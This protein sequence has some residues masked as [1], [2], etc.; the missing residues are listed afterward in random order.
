MKN[1]RLVTTRFAT[2]QDLINLQVEHLTILINKAYDE[3]ELGMWQNPGTRTNFDEVEHLIRAGALIIAEI[4]GTLV[5]SVNVTLMNEGVGE[6]GML[7][8]DP[9][10]R[11][12]GVGSALVDRAEDWARDLGCHT[13]Q[14]ELLTPRRWLHQNKEI[15]KVWY[16]N[17]G[18]RPQLTRPFETMYPKLAPLLATD[19]DFTVWHKCL[20]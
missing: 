14:L 7:V 15:L 12:V 18:Y 16:S 19:C 6:F 9:A 20:A 13:M 2:E 8:A 17:L 11:A 10:H 5:G 4:A 3:G 1:K